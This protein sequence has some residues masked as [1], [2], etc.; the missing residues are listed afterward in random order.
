MF[1]ISTKEQHQVSSWSF[2][3]HD[4]FWRWA[5]RME[6]ENISIFFR[7]NGKYTKI[8][9][10]NLEVKSASEEYFNINS[11]KPKYNQMPTTD[12]RA[13]ILIK[14]SYESIKPNRLS[15]EQLLCSWKLHNA[16]LSIVRKWWLFMFLKTRMEIHLMMVYVLFL[17]YSPLEPRNPGTITRYIYSCSGYSAP[18]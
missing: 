1:C 6:K 11:H 14:F 5:Q 3:S 2:Q 9:Y 8:R 17:S 18:S 7:Q 13:S 16:M 12:T 4:S 10:Q 15:S